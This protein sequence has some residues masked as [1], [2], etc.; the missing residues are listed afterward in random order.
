M[1]EQMPPLDVSSDDRLWV[2]LAYILSPVVPI[3]LLLME[4]KKNRPFIRAHNVQALVLGV[5]NVLW[6]SFTGV[7]VVTLCVSAALFIAQ[8][9]WGIKGYQGEY[10]NIPVLTDFVKKQGWA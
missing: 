10:V 6:T 5:I 3:I 4:D 8:I 9:Y 1:S 7:F 2:L